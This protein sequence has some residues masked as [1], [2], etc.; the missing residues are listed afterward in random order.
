MTLSFLY[1]ISFYHQIHQELVVVQ[2]LHLHTSETFFDEVAVGF[3][4]EE[5]E[6]DVVAEEVLVTGGDHA[7]QI[8]RVVD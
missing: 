5:M 8:D 2:L 3:V 4:E 1:F 7:V 6:E